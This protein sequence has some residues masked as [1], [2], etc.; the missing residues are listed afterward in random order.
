MERIEYVLVITAYLLGSIPTAVWIGRIFFGI[1]VREHGSGNAGATNT[2]RV[3]GYKAGVPVLIIDV[4]KGFFAVYLKNFFLTET[5]SHSV[6]LEIILCVAALI[7]HIFP[8]FAS[9]R[10]GKGVAT[11]LGGIIAITPIAALICAGVFI[12]TLIVS[13][14]VSLSSMTAGVAFPLVSVFLNPS[15][16]GSMIIFAV[17]VALLLIVTHRKNIQRLLKKEESRFSLISKRS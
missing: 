2:I 6:Q 7:G 17:C 15:L 14:Y 12:V 16:P 5:F 11:L 13:R 9:F 10:G 4:L 1:D 8:L 3:L